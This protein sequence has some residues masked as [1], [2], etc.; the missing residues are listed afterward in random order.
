MTSGR[1]RV[2]AAS[3][4]AP[5]VMSRSARPSAVTSWD[6]SE[7]TNDGGAE[8]APRADDGDSHYRTPRDAVTN[9]AIASTTAC[10]CSTVSSP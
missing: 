5:S 1:S 2:I 7:L 4:A 6:G 3:T 10:C 8:L 9:S